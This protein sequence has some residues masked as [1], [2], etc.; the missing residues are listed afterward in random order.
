MKL[1]IRTPQPIAF[2]SVRKN[3]AADTKSID[4]ESL[5]KSEKL[6][7]LF[8]TGLLY[9]NERRYSKAIELFQSAAEQG[10]ARANAIL[11]QMYFFGT[12][13]SKNIG[14]AVNCWEQAVK[15]GDLAAMSIFGSFLVE[16]GDAKIYIPKCVKRGVGLLQTAIEKGRP[17]AAVFL[18]R[19]YFVGDNIVQNY[20]EAERLF[21]RA[22]K[23]GIPRAMDLAKLVRVFRYLKTYN[24]NTGS[25]NDISKAFHRERLFLEELKAPLILCWIAGAIAAFNTVD[26]KYGGTFLKALGSTPDRIIST[27]EAHDFFALNTAYYMVF[28]VAFE[29]IVNDLKK[30]QMS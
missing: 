2:Q 4:G 12:G 9:Y 18:A 25:T 21:E 8:S 5:Q 15:L 23:T 16:G 17:D 29:C 19:H 20:D 24:Y 13:C 11:A 30:Y 14:K 26:T 22:A 10:S 1:S 7:N 3:D 27:L 28:D 6:Q